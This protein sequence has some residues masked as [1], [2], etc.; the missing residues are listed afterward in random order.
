MG[1]E[2]DSHKI[3]A[4]P[5]T[6]RRSAPGRRHQDDRGESLDLD[7]S[8]R[9]PCLA[10]PLPLAT[11]FDPALAAAAIA[12]ALEAKDD[13]VILEIKDQSKAEGLAEGEAR[14]LAAMWNSILRVLDRRLGSV[15]EDLRRQLDGIRSVERLE[16]IHDQALTVASVD[17][18]VLDRKP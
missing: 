9:D 4:A 13:P 1:K 10:V 2:S 18:L 11:L 12:R 15:P 8:L 16:E 17:E 5:A 3:L 14:G 7:R 6:S